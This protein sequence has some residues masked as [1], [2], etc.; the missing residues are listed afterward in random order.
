MNTETV[1]QCSLNEKHD[2]TIVNK[3]M[4]SNPVELKTQ[5]NML[6]WEQL[7]SQTTVHDAERIACRI[8]MMITEGEL[9]TS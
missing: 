6:L 8:F 7:P 5:I 1:N 9:L 4:P 2:V 3:L